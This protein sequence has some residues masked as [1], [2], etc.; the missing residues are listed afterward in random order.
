MNT[1]SQ[2]YFGESAWNDARVHLSTKEFTSVFVITDS[3]TYND[4]LPIFKTKNLFQQ[5]EIFVF[6]A[7]EINKNFETAQKIWQWAL[8]KGVDR[9]SLCIGLG[10]GVVCDI[11][12]F[13]SSVLLRGI[14]FIY[15][16]TSLMALADASVG[17]KTGINFNGYKNQIGTFN[18]PEFIICDTIFLKSLDQRNIRNGFV[19]IIKHSLLNNTPS[20]NVLKEIIWPIEESIL[21][22]L[23]QQSINYKSSVVTQ[24]FYEKNMRKVLN[25]GHTIGHAIESYYLLI[26]EDILHGE[27]VALGMKL[28]L[29]LSSNLYLW[30]KLLLDEINYLL[31][32]YLPTRKLQL[33]D[34]DLIL[35]HLKWD[36]KKEGGH[37]RFSLLEELFVPRIDCEVS[38]EKIRTTMKYY[39]ESQNV[40]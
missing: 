39:I 33:T 34:I 27:A 16:P 14:P 29:L 1:L 30:N 24:D 32:A 23:V 38:E 20:W 10:G 31:E 11:G 40:N 3:N 26:K 25:F 2:I 37:L 36:K 15:I 6:A 8:E 5:F 12:G 9:K 21:A 19:E 13:C 22:S 7:G 18:L 28:E 4:C 35:E 17:G